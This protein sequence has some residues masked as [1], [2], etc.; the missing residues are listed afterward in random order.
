MKATGLSKVQIT[1]QF[2][3]SLE[4]APIQWYYTLDPHVQSDWGKVCAAFLKQYGLNVQ[5]EVSLRDLQNTR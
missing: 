1:K 3:I 4:G 2:P 5:L